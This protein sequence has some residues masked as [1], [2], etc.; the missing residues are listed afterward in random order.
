VTAS[1]SRAHKP[2]VQSLQQ[3]H[4]VAS[5]SGCKDDKGELA[6]QHSSTGME[7]EQVVGGAPLPE[8]LQEH[9]VDAVLDR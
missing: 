9:M 7:D 1:A 6:K 4:E 8:E 3:Q 5:H 2:Q